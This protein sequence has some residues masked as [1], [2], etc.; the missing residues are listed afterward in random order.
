MDNFGIIQEKQRKY[1]LTA[2][3]ALIV[4]TLAALFSYGLVLGSLIVK[5]DANTTFDNIHSSIALFNTGIIGWLIILIADIVVAWSLY[6]F[7]KPLNN[8]LSLLGGWLRLIYAGILEIAILN[9]IF[10]SILTNSTEYFSS[11]KNNQLPIF[12]M[13]FLKAFEILW[14]FGLIIFGG[15]LMV[16]GYL[17]FKSNI[18]PKVIS[19]LLFIASISYIIIHF[20]YT[21]L[22][23]F[24]EVTATLK[25]ILSV[26]M[27]LGELSFG[28]WLL[29]KG[30]KFPRSR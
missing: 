15:H 2:G 26:P 14:S 1:A 4:M 11:F 29:F 3:I 16:V 13:L 24:N 28:I 18:V 7:L 27:V 23:Q 5:G 6:L 30:E 20:N 10:I 12:V 22:P 21:F 9:L 8:H 17:T 19:L 25:S